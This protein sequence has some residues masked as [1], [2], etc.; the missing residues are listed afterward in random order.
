MP[1]I[2]IGIIQDIYTNQGNPTTNW[3]SIANEV[4]VAHPDGS[5]P[6]HGHLKFRIADIPENKFIIS[7]TLNLYFDNFN[8]PT[9]PILM[10]DNVE[11]WDASTVTWNTK[12][13]RGSNIT[14]IGNPANGPRSFDVTDYVKENYSNSQD[15]GVTF[16]IDTQDSVDARYRFER[17]TD[18]DPLKRPTLDIVYSDTIPF[19]PSLNYPV[20]IT[21]DRSKDL[22]LQWN[23]PFHLETEIIWNDGT[24]HTINLDGNLFEY[25]IPANTIN[26]GNVTWKARQ[27]YQDVGFSEYSEAFFIAADRPATPVITTTAL[28]TELPTISWTSVNQTGFILRI[29]EG[30]NIVVNQTNFISSLSYSVNQK[31]KDDTVYTIELSIRDDSGLWSD[32]DTETITSNFPKPDIPTFTIIEFDDHV[33]LDISNGL[34]T[35]SNQVL[36]LIDDT[37]QVIKETEP[38]ETV[39]IYELVSGVTESLKIRAFREGGGFS[40]SIIKT[41]SIKVKDS[42]IVTQNLQTILNLSKSPDKSSN[43]SINFSEQ[44]FVGRNLPALVSG[45]IKQRAPNWSFETFDFKDVDRFNSILGKKCLFRDRRGFIGWFVITNLL[46]NDLND[47]TVISITRVTE[48]SR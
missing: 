4:T 3:D 40:D 6:F 44:M 36:K 8:T 13:S 48:V 27:R 39:A 12:P 41:T 30:E 23:G 20:N 31:L 34:N 15:Y 35:S 11:D 47:S 16:Y 2:T 33:H 42:Q 9:L 1:E 45:Q 37:Y 26:A 7:A 24:D 38:N 21:I 25:T 29:L 28:T 10:A 19:A 14:N 17:H 32:V 22:T 43:D 5:Q 18:A 46:V